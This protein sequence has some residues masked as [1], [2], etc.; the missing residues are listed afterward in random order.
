ME[1]YNSITPLT[2]QVERVSSDKCKR[3]GYGVGC[4]QE[5][6]GRCKH[7]GLR[8]TDSDLVEV[9][10][11]QPLSQGGKD[12]YKNL[13]SYTAIVTIIKTATDNLM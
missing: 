8:F 12:E 4:D 5:Q 9:D 10:H 7:C 2:H 1:R 13:H 11:L 6:R 3:M